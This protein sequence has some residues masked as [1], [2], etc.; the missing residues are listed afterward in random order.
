MFSI[1]WHSSER[2]KSMDNIKY[3][4][5]T[6]MW[7]LK[8]Q[9]P[10]LND[11][12]EWYDGDFGN[13]VYYLDWDQILKYHVGAG[14]TGIELMFHMKPYIEQFFG[15]KKAPEPPKRDENGEG[16]KMPQGN[17]FADISLWPELAYIWMS[18]II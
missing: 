7:G 5:Q 6:N 4:Y 18:R 10:K 13:S 3:S 15:E 11:W 9:F 1:L 14:I 8:V 16:P 17:P 2:E 12:H